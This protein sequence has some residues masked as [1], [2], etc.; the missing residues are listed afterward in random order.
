MLHIIV[1]Q[2]IWITANFEHNVIES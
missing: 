2:I 1:R